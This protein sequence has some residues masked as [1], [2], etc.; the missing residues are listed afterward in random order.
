MASVPNAFA[1]KTSLYSTQAGL[2]PA[3]ANLVERRLIRDA[4]E[5]YPP[6]ALRHL[7]VPSVEFFLRNIYWNGDSGFEHM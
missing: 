3:V 1:L 6:P 2:E 4:T 7:R 5:P